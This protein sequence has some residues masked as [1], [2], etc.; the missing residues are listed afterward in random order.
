MKFCCI[1]FVVCS[2]L[3]DIMLE[4]LI[5]IFAQSFHQF[6]FVVIE[7]F[8]RLG[9]ILVQEFGK[10]A[11]VFLLPDPALGFAS[12]SHMAYIYSASED[13]AQQLRRCRNLYLMPAV[14]KLKVATP[15]LTS[16]R[17]C[18]FFHFSNSSEVVE[19]VHCG[20]INDNK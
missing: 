16:L 3:F 20:F 17:D 10:C 4:S 15:T 12:Q 19:I 11:Y 1:Y 14:C 2:F 9:N 7:C 13:P 6:I 18:V 5:M 8:T